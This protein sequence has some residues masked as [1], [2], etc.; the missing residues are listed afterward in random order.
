MPD[1]PSA[2][3]SDQAVIA[4]L[5]EGR[6]ELADALIQ[7]HWEAIHRFCK[8]YLSDAHHAEDVTQATFA[9]LVDGTD[10]PTG[11]VKPWL[12]KIARN[13]CL[14]ILRRQHR[15]P[16]H[17]RPI[18]TG[19]DRAGGGSGPA[20]KAARNERQDLIRQFIDEMPEDYRS[21]LILKYFEGLSRAEMAEAL[22]VS[23]AAVK[24]RLVRASEKLQDELKMIT[25]SHS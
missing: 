9:R 24:G 17:N 12:Y 11:A 1:Q 18:R 14:D 8:R 3:L 19:F 6:A 25:R 4:G 16:T 13:R 20:T 2:N 23:E 5:R 21:V 7:R 22:G 10:L 15:S